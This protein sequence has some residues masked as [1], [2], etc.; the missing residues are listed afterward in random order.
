M[1]IKVLSIFILLSFFTGII[2]NSA[3]AKELTIYTYDS[4]N[5]E[6]GPG[7]IVFKRFRSNVIAN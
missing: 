5:S 7:P 2:V 3:A 4:F 1:Q 6:W